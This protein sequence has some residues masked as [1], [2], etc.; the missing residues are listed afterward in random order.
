M[1]T[2]TLVS[3]L[4]LVL[5]VLV[6]AGGC[7]T[8][9][10]A[11]R[12]KELFTKLNGTWVNEEYDTWQGWSSKLVIK[13]DGTYET[14]GESSDSDRSGYG[15]YEAIVDT[16]TDPEGNFFYKATLKSHM[17]I[18]VLY[19][20]GKINSSRAEWETVWSG[21]DFPPEIDSSHSNYLIY[22]RQ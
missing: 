4:I 18:S 17:T 19:E 22:Y 15:E 10:K 9:K 3:I 21:L 12:E 11:Q 5:A 6:I 7:A 14:F 13:S 2:R 20:I 16:W 1:K 8:G